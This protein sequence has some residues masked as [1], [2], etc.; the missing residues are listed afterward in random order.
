[1][2][3]IC[4][5]IAFL[6]ALHCTN[7]MSA[8]S[9]F[10]IDSVQKIELFFHQTNWDYLLDTAKQGTEETYLIADSVR[11]NGIVFDSVGVKYK[12]NSSYK[13]MFKINCIK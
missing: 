7:K 4:L 10:Q 11:V 9:F 12:G 13:S 2:K 6:V 1:M 8:Q 5:A 3:K